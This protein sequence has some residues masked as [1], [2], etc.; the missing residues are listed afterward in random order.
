ML[1]LKRV[2]LFLE[3]IPSGNGIA[4]KDRNDVTE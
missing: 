4:N 1:F 3:N 2:D